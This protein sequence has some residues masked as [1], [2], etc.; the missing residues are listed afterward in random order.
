[1]KNATFYFVDR[2]PEMYDAK[3]SIPTGIVELTGINMNENSPFVQKMQVEISFANL[4]KFITTVFLILNMKYY[5]Q[6]NQLR[7]NLST[8]CHKNDKK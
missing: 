6:N 2:Q 1:M 4:I 8:C 5:L 7:L 3:A